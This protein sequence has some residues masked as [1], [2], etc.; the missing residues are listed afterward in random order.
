MS[1]NLF[2]PFDE[3]D[4][5]GD[6][7]QKGSVSATRPSAAPS[8]YEGAN[9][10]DDDV[11]KGSS[12]ELDR[13]DLADST[14]RPALSGIDSLPVA[15][16]AVASFSGR[17]SDAAALS[18][19][20]YPRAPERLWATPKYAWLVVLRQ[21]ELRRDLAALR[22][23]RSPDVPLYEAALVAYNRR[24]FRRGALLGGA[25]VLAAAVLFFMPVI[26]RFARAD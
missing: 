2:S 18:I 20:R 9:D 19:A 5:D 8:L 6:S 22:H 13:P 11:E 23:R 24:A 14:T 17:T 25:L 3:D 4:D 16:R 1:D 7:L 26:L 12:L 10:F 15:P 21:V